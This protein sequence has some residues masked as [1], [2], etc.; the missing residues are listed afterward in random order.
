MYRIDKLSLEIRD[1]KGI[2]NTSVKLQIYAIFYE[3]LVTHTH[4]DW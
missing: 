2:C 1:R 3:I 4:F